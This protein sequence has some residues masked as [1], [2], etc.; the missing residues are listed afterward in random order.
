MK[1]GDLVRLVR[2]QSGLSQ[3]DFAEKIGASRSSINQWENGYHKPKLENVLVIIDH[4]KP[5]QDLSDKLLA[6]VNG[7]AN[8]ILLSHDDHK[9]VDQTISVNKIV[10]ALFDLV[11]SGDI[12]FRK[13][14]DPNQ[15]ATHI[16]NKLFD[17]ETVDQLKI[18]A[19]KN[20][21]YGK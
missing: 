12:T 20:G 5:K 14:A 2:G 7:L 18:V 6:S 19:E 15:S 3:K 17:I 13:G 1:T 8:G 21:T 16:Y 10:N 9:S 11:I 4:I